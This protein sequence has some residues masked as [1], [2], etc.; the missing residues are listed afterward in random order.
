[1]TKFLFFL[2]VLL[3]GSGCAVMHRSAIGEVL[4]EKGGASDRIELGVS[5]IGVD[6]ENL[7]KDVASIAKNSGNSSLQGFGQMVEFVTWATTQSPRI[8]NPTTT[9]TWADDLVMELKRHCP[10][11]RISGIQT[12]RESAEYPYVSGEIVRVRATCYRG[13]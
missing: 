4:P 2:L 10:N 6:R 13:G 8:G 7:S 3:G 1:M 12:L 5:D 9:D 11:G